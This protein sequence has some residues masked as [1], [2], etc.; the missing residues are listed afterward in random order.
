MVM[1]LWTLAH[2]QVPGFLVLAVFGFLEM[3]GDDDGGLVVG[4]EDGE[5]VP[6]VGGDDPSTSLRTGSGGEA[7]NRST[8]NLFEL[9]SNGQPGA[10]VPT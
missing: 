3:R 6:G 7:C 10:A 9:R 8:R 1:H 2:E 4:G 5:D